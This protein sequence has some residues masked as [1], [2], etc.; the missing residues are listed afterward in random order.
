MRQKNYLNTG[1]NH[2][3]LAG[4]LSQVLTDG[5]NTYLYGPQRI[6]QYDSEGIDY[7][8]DDASLCAPL[9][10]NNV[11][12]MYNP[13]NV[14]TLSRNYEPYGTTYGAMGNR[15]TAYGFTGEWMDG[16]GLVNLRARYYKSSIGHFISKDTWQGNFNNPLSL[17]VWNY[18]EANPINRIDPSGFC[19]VTDTACLEIS[20]E[21]KVYYGWHIIGSWQLR[22]VNLFRG[23][24]KQI[25]NYFGL[26]GGNGGGRMR[27]LSPVYLSHASEFWIEKGYH[28]VEARSIILIPSIS[29]VDIIHEFGHI[30][31]NVTGNTRYA[32]IFGG[33]P[34]DDMVRHLGV[35]PSRCSLRFQ[36][37]DY[38]QMLRDE[39]AELPY[40]DYAYHGPSED[41][42]VTFEKIVISDSKIQSENPVR[43][44]WMTKFIEQYQRTLDPFFDPLPIPIPDCALPE[45]L[46]TPQPSMNVT[47]ISGE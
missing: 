25:S 11:R 27:A 47:P 12:Q 37:S 9:G 46:I 43:V 10:V 14:L 21:L 22:E 6:S 4:S 2:L 19:S 16:T 17:N 41:F 1:R 7:F 28:H 35:D 31:D 39:N 5:T 30:V 42:A 13:S 26:N 3:D 33:G 23:A 15:T 32:S 29:Q 18:V 45:V 40:Y 34:S 20:H 36:C 38:K 8:I 44:T 24:A